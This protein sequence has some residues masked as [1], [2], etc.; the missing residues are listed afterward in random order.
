MSTAICNECG[1][2]VKKVWL[3]G[4]KGSHSY[5]SHNDRSGESCKGAGWKVPDVLD[6]EEWIARG[7]K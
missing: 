2:K 1:Q 4:R 7:G 3:A 5:D 6:V